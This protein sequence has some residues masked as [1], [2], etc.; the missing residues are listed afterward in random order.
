MPVPVVG[1]PPRR[2][3]NVPVEGEVDVAHV[4]PAHG[5]A[6]RPAD[7][8]GPVGRIAKAAAGDLERR[9]LPEALL[10]PRQV[11]PLGAHRLVGPTGDQVRYARGT[12]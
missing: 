9:G 8:P 12:R 4:R 5:V 11:D 2:G 6:H 7:D 3:R 1:D 10:E